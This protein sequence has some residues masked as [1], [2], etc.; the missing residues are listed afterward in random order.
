VNIDGKRVANNV[1]RHQQ[2]HRR[3]NPHQ[4]RGPNAGG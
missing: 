2:R 4:R 3:R 1:T